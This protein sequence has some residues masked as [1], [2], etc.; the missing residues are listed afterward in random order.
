[1]REQ[2]PTSLEVVAI[3]SAESTSAAA[4]RRPALRETARARTPIGQVG[5]RQ[6]QGH[7]M[8]LP[9]PLRDEEHRQDDQRELA[10][11]PRV[12]A[13]VG[14]RPAEPGEQ[15]DQADREHLDQQ[16]RRASGRQET[17]LHVELDV[18]PP[19]ADLASV[20]SRVRTPT[21]D[22]LISCSLDDVPRRRTG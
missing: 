3:S 5:V 8:V 18:V 12:V 13:P 9:A 22:W 19:V 2:A 10:E 14:L 1:M 7:V 6:E 17:R 15:A 20:R 16:A 21:I 4:E 11:Q